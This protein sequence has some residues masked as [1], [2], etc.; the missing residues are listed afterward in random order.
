VRAKI[1]DIEFSKEVSMSWCDKLASTPGFGIRL[2]KAF[3]PVASLLD[4]ITP[5]TSK[6]VDKDK[7]AFSVDQQDLFSCTLNTFDGYQY[8]LNPEALAVE[9]RHRLRF[10]AQSAG[11]PSAELISKPLPYTEMLPKVTKLLVEM[12]EL[13]TAGKHRKLNRIGVI[14]TTVVNEDEVPP[15]ITRFLE[16]VLKPWDTSSEHYNIELVARLPKVKGTAKY[17]RCFHLINKPEDSEGLVTVRLDWQRYF[18]D[19]KALS[20]TTLPVLAAAA[21]KDALAYFEDIAEGER[22]DV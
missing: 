2:D 7:P 14:S 10:K 16:H 11:P 13:V 1:S 19:D 12:T 21:C 6:W 3:A 15:G 20:M 8:V 4:P 17:D 18:E 5:I 22:F 9:F